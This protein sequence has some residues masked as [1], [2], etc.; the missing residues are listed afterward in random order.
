MNGILNINKPSGITS[1]DVV[2]KLRRYLRKTKIGHTGTLDPMASGVLP[3]CIGQ[4]TKIAQF[5]S[6]GDKEYHAIGKLGLQ[7]DTLDKTGQTINQHDASKI[8]ENDINDI[9]PE[10]R[11]SIEQTPP[12]YSA[13]KKNGQRLYNLARQGITVERPPR[14][15]QIKRL[16]MADFSHPYFSLEIECS[17]GTYIRSLVADIGQKLGCGAILWELVRTRC[18]YFQIK[19]SVTLEQAQ[20]L[21]EQNQLSSALIDLNRALDHL[22][23]VIISDSGVKLVQN[24][25]VLT[26][27][28]ILDFSAKEIEEGSVIRVMSHD[29]KLIALGR[30][31]QRIAPQN[32]P[33]PGTT[34]LHAKPVFSQP[35]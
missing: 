3:L 17:T 1:H 14:P 9:L 18:S 13:L 12:M 19:N 30:A 29:Y 31:L 10:F 6:S 32:K 21:I 28:S 7:T 16:E 22:P 15:V 27:E 23:R 26:T 35:E 24:G 25:V 8:T 5:I 2:A 4:A 34:I 11:G 33:S 20:E